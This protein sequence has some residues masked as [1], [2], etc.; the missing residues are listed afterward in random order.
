MKFNLRTPTADSEY[1]IAS[2]ITKTED[3]LVLTKSS[4]MS[5]TKDEPITTLTPNDCSWFGVHLSGM[6]LYQSNT[7]LTTPTTF[8]TG[9]SIK[10]EIVLNDWLYEDLI[11]PENRQLT[12]PQLQA[13][14]A[15]EIIEDITTAII[16]YKGA[17]NDN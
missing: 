16:T 10:G 1:E 6:I 3:S 13:K 7:I 5:R 11:I 4:N 12:L 14:I 9:T 8:N 2:V 15:E 17:S